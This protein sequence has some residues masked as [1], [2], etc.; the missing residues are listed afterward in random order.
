MRVLFITNLPSPYRVAFLNK[1]GTMCNLTVLFERHNASDRDASWVNKSDR[2]YREIF[3]NGKNV[4]ADASVSLG[5]IS[6]IRVT[7][8]ILLS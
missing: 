2:K 5:A 1:L 3:L 8:T 4:G 7:N 6:H